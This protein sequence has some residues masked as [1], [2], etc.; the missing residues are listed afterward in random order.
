[1]KDLHTILAALESCTY[2]T[3][4]ACEQEFNDDKVTEAISIVKQMMQAK[5]VAEIGVSTFTWLSD[6]PACGAKLYAVHQAVPGHLEEQ[7]NGAVVETRSESQAVS[8]E[9][10]LIE[11]KLPEPHQLVLVAVGQIVTT[12]SYAPGFGWAWEE[13]DDDDYDYDAD[14]VITHWMPL[15]AAPTV[16]A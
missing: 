3:Y 14:S 12:G 8:L 9:W 13:L 5:P 7:P 4:G 15:P 2:S 10:N 11:K 1:M 16:T 6:R